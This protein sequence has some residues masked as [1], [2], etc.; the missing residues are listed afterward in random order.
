MPDDS[1][2]FA[3]RVWVGGLPK[4]IEENEVGERF[5]RFGPIESV[6]VRSSIRDTFAFIQ[7]RH[8]KDAKA[9]V[10]KMDQV[11]LFGGR[12]C[13]A[14]ATGD[15]KR[16]Q[17][18]DV[19]RSDSRGRGGGGGKGGGGS[20]GGRQGGN[21]GRG[22]T[23]SRDAGKDR[24]RGRDWDRGRSRGDDW[25]SRPYRNSQQHEQH[26]RSRSWRDDKGGGGGGGGHRSRSPWRQRGG[27]RG[28]DRNAPQSGH[29]K[30]TV[31]HLPP[32]MSWHELKDLGRSFGASLTFARTYRSNS[33]YCGMIEFQEKADADV[34]VRELDKRRFEGS[35]ERLRCYHGDTSSG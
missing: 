18:Q 27:D 29:H 12:V 9:A 10:A 25:N 13:V 20:Y 4:G 14:F 33:I 11:T 5:E 15:Q 17:Y 35:A 1:P 26:P 23:D 21:Y 2:G 28:N 30:I 34:A 3:D 22:R 7:Y 24:D 31:E 32:D 19:R 6:M 16:H 8:Q